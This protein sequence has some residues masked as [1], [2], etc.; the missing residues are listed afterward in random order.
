MTRAKWNAG[1]A[2]VVKC[3]QKK[4]FSYLKNYFCTSVLSKGSVKENGS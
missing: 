2:Q 3:H 1:V 4:L